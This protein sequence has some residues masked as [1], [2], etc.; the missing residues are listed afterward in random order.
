MYGF[1][2]DLQ[3][4]RENA[5]KILTRMSAIDGVKSIESTIPEKI[6]LSVCVRMS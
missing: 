3:E 2:F 4:D 6:F 5:R 1:D